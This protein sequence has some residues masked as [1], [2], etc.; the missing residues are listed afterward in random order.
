M[1]A[2]DAAPT[3][4]RLQRRA[5]L[6]NDGGYGDDGAQFCNDGG[7]GDDGGDAN[8]AAPTQRRLQ[9]RDGDDGER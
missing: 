1:T 4:Q 5:Q 6:C 7:Y 8:D 2:N 3:Q 9:R